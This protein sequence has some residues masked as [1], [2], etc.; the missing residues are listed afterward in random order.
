MSGGNLRV[1]RRNTSSCGRGSVNSCTSAVAGTNARRRGAAGVLREVVV[2][3]R[4]ARSSPS[5]G[6]PRVRPCRLWRSIPT[7]QA[8][9]KDYFAQH[10]GLAGLCQFDFSR[11]GAASCRAGPE[12]EAISRNT[13]ISRAPRGAFEPVRTIGAGVLCEV[14]LAGGLR[15]RK[16][17][18]RRAGALPPH[19]QVLSQATPAPRTRATSRCSREA[20]D[21][22]NVLTRY[23]I[24]TP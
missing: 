22:A 9:G 6:T 20:A 8:P 4:A 17:R 14:T 19:L 7:A 21:Y 24:E 13:P 18:Q 3:R 5:R 12:K 16:P 15:G 11:V 1:C 23:Y 2:R 10:T